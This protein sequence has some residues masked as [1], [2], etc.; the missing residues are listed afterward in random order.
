MLRSCSLL[1]TLFVLLAATSLSAANITWIG[2]GNQ[3]SEGAPNNVNWSPADEPDPDDVAIFNSSNGV[4]LGSN[5]AVSGLTL[6]GDAGLL[7]NNYSLTVNGATTV[8]GVG[9]I[10][11]VDGDAAL[12]TGQNVTVNSGANFFLDGG[13]VHLAAPGV[14]S[15]LLAV[16]NGGLLS[17]NGTIIFDDIP[18][19][20]TTVISNAGTITASNP[21]SLLLFPPAAASLTFD[22]WSANVR[23]DL[24]G[25]ADNGIVNVTRNQTL[26]VNIP[27]AD[28]FNSKMNLGHNATLNIE[29]PW[30]FSGSGALSVDNGA[31]LGLPGIPAGVATIGGGTMS[32]TGG[33]I[34]VEDE[35]GTLQFN[36]MLN[37]TSGNLANHGLLIFNAD[38]TIGAGANVTMPSDSS[39]LTVKANS[40][41]QINQP[42]FKL[43]GSETSA[44]V[45][46][47]ESGGRL[48][49]NLGAAGDRNLGGV[50]NLQGGEL[51]VLTHNDLWSIDGVLNIAASDTTSTI[52]GEIVTFNGAEVTLQPGST[53]AVTATNQW[54]PGTSIAMG[55]GSK[56]TLATATFNGP[57]AIEGPGSLTFTHGS[58]VQSHLKIDTETF[59]WDGGTAGNTHSIANGVVFTIE[60]TALDDD[61]DMDDNILISGNGASLIV[62]SQPKWTMQGTLTTN[63][64]A[65]GTATIGG[66]STMALGSTGVMN[67]NGNTNL[68][69]RVAFEDDSTTV[70]AQTAKLT[71]KGGTIDSPNVISGGS[72]N[73]T[74]TLAMDAGQT[75]RGHGVINA[76][77]VNAAEGQLLAAG[78]ELTVNG[79]INDIGVLGTADADGVLHIPGAWSTGVAVDVRLAGGELKGGLVTVANATGIRG[80]GL[81]SARLVNNTLLQA[82]GGTLAF[83]TADND[84]DWDGLAND[85]ALSA[86]NG[87]TLELR[88]N[89]QFNFFGAA[90]ATG[91]SRIRAKGFGLNLATGSSL[92]LSN[93][94]FESQRG[95]TIGGDI[96]VASGPHSTLEVTPNYFLTLEDS[97]KVTLNGDLRILNNNI[98]IEAGAL[99][100]GAGALVIPNGSHLVADA[101]AKVDV[102]LEMGGAFRPAG[103][104]AVGRVDVKDYQQSAT[105][106]LFIE[107]TGTGLNQFD[108]LLV[109]GTAQL[110][111]N[112][113][114]DIDGGFIPTAGQTFSFLTASNGVFGTFDNVDVSGMPAGLAF[115][116]NYLAN[117]VQ[118]QVV[119]QTSYA[120]DFDDDGDVDAT[121][122]EY[123]KNAFGLNQL[124]DANGDNLTDGSDFLIWQRQF[125]SGSALPAA[126]STAATIPEP[127]TGALLLLASTALLAV[128][129]RSRQ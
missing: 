55:A 15:A 4:L 99:F 60:T 113:D 18:A 20:P 6:S 10:L 64:F 35:D 109:N 124:G 77:I 71:L 110:A 9:T 58:S 117:A 49:L 62:N 69:G 27:L 80:K 54:A 51:N 126:Q 33:T 32:Q 102:L 24:D 129:R 19:G 83:G 45:L 40:N 23:I 70:I 14:P 82:D 88:D 94:V 108:R 59:D 44:N 87:S 123:W 128:R 116:V 38:A 90:T 120:A 95:S 101:N 36:A 7:L 114:L 78:G 86:I 73:G 115:H 79:A 122:L 72:I 121:D 81:V 41:V 29:S 52:S 39:S 57:A 46:S 96:V 103:F 53:L 91:G 3:W 8:S 21:P 17:G 107:L 34:T 50:I 11:S 43:D 93:S 74:G 119:N 26:N 42:S 97:A 66:S 31:V 65:V 85:G 61:G 1:S 37:M 25:F 13:T 2:G 105:G 56:L 28:A 63:S 112:L 118:L 111:G 47:I 89:A 127:A 30:T 5:N 125:G 67:V 48:G 106:A 104:D 92:Q 16:N 84:N 98:R 12:F 22:A 75:L 68:A 100:A 76:N